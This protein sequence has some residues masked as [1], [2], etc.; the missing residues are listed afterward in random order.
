MDDQQQAPATPH[1]T[2]GASAPMGNTKMEATV[3]SHRLTEERARRDDALSQAA[4]AQKA[5]EKMKAQLEAVT[6]ELS[7][8]QSTHTQELHLVEMGFK[9]PSIRRFLRREYASA[10]SEAGE[11][12]ANF[13]EWLE[14]NR[15]DPLYSPHFDRLSQGA[16][17]ESPTAPEQTQDPTEAL[18]A[19]VR[20]TLN[21]NPERGT[22]TPPVHHSKEYGADEIRKVRA[23]NGGS[24][25][26][27]KENIMAAL[28]AQGLIK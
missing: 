23:K 25:G 3:P 14:S 12:A 8:L 5:M 6:S 1:T 11:N 21:G 17:V 4:S 2:N 16:P 18:L 20:D 28:R 27:Q 24:L 19:A 7:N 9:A 13:A 22:G 26:D 10:A 15:E